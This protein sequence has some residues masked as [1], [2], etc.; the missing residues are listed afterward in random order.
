MHFDLWQSTRIAVSCI[1]ISLFVF[2]L[3]ANAQTQ[4]VSPADIHKELVSSSQTRQKN[5]E[6]VQKLI[7][8][9]LAQKSSAGAKVD[10][11]RVNAAVSILSDADLAQLAARADKAQADFAA[12]RISE[13]DL[14]FIIL[15]FVALVVIIVA[16]R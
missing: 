2:S 16:A 9:G 5:L 7:S 6:K 15:G 4:V 14:L 10:P 8:T 3:N 13:R 1:V 12:G 11:A